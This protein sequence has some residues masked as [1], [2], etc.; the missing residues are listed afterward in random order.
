MWCKWDIHYLY[1]QFSGFAIITNVKAGSFQES[2][3]N[4]PFVSIWNAPTRVCTEQYG[5]EL[6]LSDFDI[7]AN[8]GDTFI[9]DEVTVFYEGRLGLYP[10]I[11]TD[12]SYEN[13]GLPQVC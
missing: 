11:R 8:K 12:G 9:G 3:S 2:F 13:G 5:V 6:D 4:K 1:I 7:V 10:W